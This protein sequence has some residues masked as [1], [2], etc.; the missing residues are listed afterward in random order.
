MKSKLERLGQ[1]LQ[2][3]VLGPIVNPLYLDL[4]AD[5]ISTVF[6][7]GT[8]RSGTTWVSEV[9]NYKRDHR[10]MFEPFWGLRVPECRD[11]LMQQYIR[12]EDRPPSYLRAA[13]AILS[14][15]IRNPWVDKFHRTFVARRRLIKDIRANLFLKWLYRQYPGLPIILLLRHP[16]AVARSYLRRRNPYLDLNVYLQQPELVDDFLA[17]LV[18]EIRSAETDFEKIVFRWCIENYVPLHQFQKGQIHLTFYEQLCTEPESA[19]DGMFGFLERSYDRSIYRQ[20]RTPSPEA[21]GQAA[22]LTQNNLVSSWTKDVSDDQVKRMVEI[23]GLFGLDRIY[24]ADPMPHPDGAYA[25][26]KSEQERP[27]Q[28]TTSRH[29]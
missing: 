13:D 20:L 2:K 19:L 25:L 27:A 10:Y 9:I 6:L 7:A 16:C 28:T 11:F 24:D 26:L 17:P 15:Q 29:L 14:G 23:L 22:I 21:R 12:P 4:G 1:K 18:G 3:H 8:E 5:H